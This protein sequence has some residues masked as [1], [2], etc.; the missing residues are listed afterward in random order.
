MFIVLPHLHIE[1]VC[2][3]NRVKWTFYLL[4]ILRFYQDIYLMNKYQKCCMNLF[5]FSSCYSH[6]LPPHLG[7]KYYRLIQIITLRSSKVSIFIYIE[8]LFWAYVT[9]FSEE[10]IHFPA[11]LEKNPFI[12][13]L[14]FKWKI[15]IILHIPE[16]VSNKPHL[17]KNQATDI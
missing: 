2:I 8:G 12:R 7:K 6:R 13:I 11:C 4:D 15:C 17:G 10:N 9:M 14:L 1:Y 16:T 3:L 5:W